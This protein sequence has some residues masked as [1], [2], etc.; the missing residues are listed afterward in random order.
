MEDVF[1]LDQN[2][3]RIGIIDSYKSLIWAKRYYTT[4]DCEIYMA[5]DDSNLSLL[6]PKNY[7]AREDDDMI[8]QIRN[9]ELDTDVENG[10]Y[11]IVQA[12]DVRKLLDQRIIW[13]TM[14]ASGENLESFIRRMVNL[15]CITPNLSARRF[16][17]ANGNQLLFLGNV[18]GFTDVITEQV[19][20]K[21]VGEKIR[22][23][24]L[25]NGWGYRIV[26]S[27]GGL[28][29][30]L[31]E[32]EDKSDYVVFSENYENLIT[33]KY[34]EDNSNLGNVALVGGQ[35]E[36]SE[37]SRNVSGYEE[38]TDR[39]E[40]F[41]DAKDISKT[42]TWAD[43]TNLY[44]TTDSGGQGYIAMSGGSYVYKLN[45]LNVQVVDSDQLTWLKA[46]FPG[47]TEI[48]I[49]GNA[50]YQVYNEIVA[51]IPS[52][53]P[54][55]T[56]NVTLR[57]LVYSVYLLTRGYEKLAEYGAI[58]AFEGTIEPGTTFI[59]KQDYNL[60]DIVTVANNYGISTKARITEVIEVKD[61]N[62][63]S[64][65]PTFEYFSMT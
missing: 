51:D 31:Y 7:I 56:D 2:L 58:T 63:Y 52:D 61:D 9:I 33:S 46:N 55:D 26:L 49:S 40:I 54:Q 1:V 21:N 34:V 23:Y 42:I 45:Y 41:V 44:P 53:S 64:V 15:T 29:F 24:C 18:A 27:N 6:Q 37:R 65:Q 47:G 3:N 48:T 35:G 17:K 38:S 50:Y 20:Y 32:G 22:E 25:A 60:G 4:G 28:Y 5:A 14:S 19:T 43:L 16:N 11:L 57:D 30:Q 36:G 13:S 8:C 39:Y 59:Y 62:G 12:F 10:D